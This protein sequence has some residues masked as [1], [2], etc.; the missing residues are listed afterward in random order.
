MKAHPSGS[1]VTLR[2]NNEHVVE[3]TILK[4]H[5]EKRFSIFPAL[6]ACAIQPLPRITDTGE[7]VLFRFHLEDWNNVVN[8]F[9]DERMIPYDNF[10]VLT[11]ETNRAKGIQFLSE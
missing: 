5:M 11:A 10:R 6:T 3:V 2:S 7:T 4:S 8:D 1:R 9:L